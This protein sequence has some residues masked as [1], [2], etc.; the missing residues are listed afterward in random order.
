MKTILI[1]IIAY[2]SIAQ[3][4]AEV[5]PVKTFSCKSSYS[6]FDTTFQQGDGLFIDVYINSNGNMD[7]KASQ[8]YGPSYDILLDEEFLIG[9]S[10]TT[11]STTIQESSY[12]SM[13]FLGSDNWGLYLKTEDSQRPSFLPADIEVMCK[14]VDF[15]VI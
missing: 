4:R 10:K 13:V 9:E 3:I 14:Q 7:V 2:I 11:V 12:L 15:A 5:A 6:M 1:Y 8:M